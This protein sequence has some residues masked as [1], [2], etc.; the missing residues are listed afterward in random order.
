DEAC[1]YIEDGRLERVRLARIVDMIRS[2]ISPDDNSVAANLADHLAGR[3]DDLYT[4]LDF[5]TESLVAVS[6]RESAL[7]IS[8]YE[9]ERECSTVNRQKSWQ[10]T[11]KYT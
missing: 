4:A 5:L 1:R 10:F 3:F 6:D 9:A 7:K 8:Q 11:P 2:G